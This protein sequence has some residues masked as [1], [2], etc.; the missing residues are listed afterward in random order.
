MDAQA[1]YDE[2]HLTRFSDGGT[3]ENTGIGGLLAY[4]DIDS[5]IAFINAPEPLRVAEHGI[6][7]EHGA[8]TPDTQIYIEQQVAALFGY[9]PYQDGVGYKLYAGDESPEDPEYGHSQVFESSAFAQVLR[10]LWSASGNRES[11]G[12]NTRPAIARVRLRVVPNP[13][14]GIPGRGHETDANPDPITLLLVY[15]NR[16]RAW[17]DQLSPEVQAILGDFDDPESF[18]GFP[19]VSTFSTHLSKTT[20]NLLA[21]LTSWS[22]ANPDDADTFISLFTADNGQNTP[23][24]C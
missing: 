5:V 10:A 23:A 24:P 11:P 16:V 13:W 7:D 6:L 20:I 9:Q 12:A 17:H 18:D 22:V 2:L 4:Q 15:T 1:P 3:I 14:F 19:H 8:P 21:Q